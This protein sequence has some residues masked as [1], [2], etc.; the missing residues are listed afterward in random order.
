MTVCLSLSL[1]VCVFVEGVPFSKVQPRL[2][3]GSANPPVG[4]PCRGKKSQP[5]LTCGVCQTREFATK[6][7]KGVKLVCLPGANSHKH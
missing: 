5:V 1:C 7:Q 6:P 3:I 2:A 4:S